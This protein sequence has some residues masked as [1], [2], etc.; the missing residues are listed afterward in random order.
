[1]PDPPYAWPTA[2]VSH[3]TWSVRKYSDVA[4]EM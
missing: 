2:A 1:L 4:M 3:P